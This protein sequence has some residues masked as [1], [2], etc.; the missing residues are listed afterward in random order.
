MSADPSE[1]L[2]ANTML[3]VTFEN[4]VYELQNGISYRTVHSLRFSLNLICL[5]PVGF[6]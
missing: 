4:Y 6:R 1:G 3:D 2:P 5:L